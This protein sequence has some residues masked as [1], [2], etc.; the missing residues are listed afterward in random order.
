MKTEITV[1]YTVAGQAITSPTPTG[2]SLGSSV[3]RARKALASLF[4]DLEPELARAHAAVI[5][6]RP[7][8]YALPT[9]R[10]VIC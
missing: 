6:S 10:I 5:T 3:H 9:N 1:R 8:P 4:A 7:F 2:R